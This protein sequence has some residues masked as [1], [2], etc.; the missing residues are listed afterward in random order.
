MPD[1]EI[2]LKRQYGAD[3]LSGL[4]AGAAV[5]PLIASVDKALAENASGRSTMGQSMIS[6]LKQIAFHPIKFVNTFAYRWIW[7][8]YGATYVTANICISTCKLKEVDDGIPKLISTFIVNASTCIAKDRA[9]AKRYATTAAK[10]MPW[11]SYGSWVVRD[12]GS[13]Y[14]F[15][16]LPPIVAKY[17]TKYTGSERSAYYASQFILPLAC[18]TFLAPPHVLG[19]DIYNNPNNNFKQRL[20]FVQKDYPKYVGLKMIRQAP[21]WSIGTILNREI[22][23]KIGILK[24]Y[25]D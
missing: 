17:A 13:M 3:I 22:R 2:D 19:Y 1:Q 9:F 16:T 21:P 20:A 14:V 25:G 7:L 10:P 12:V 11:G 5:S 18:Q 4:I 24:S 8:V 23:E 15:W 6:S